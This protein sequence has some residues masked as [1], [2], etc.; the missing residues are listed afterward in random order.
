MKLTVTVALLGISAALIAADTIA[1]LG[2]YTAG[3]RRH[4]AFRPRQIVEAPKFTEAADRAWVQTPVDAF[5]LAQLKKEGL[6]P[7]PAADRLTLVRRLYHDLTGLPPSPAQVAAFLNDRSPD[8]YSRLV[9]TLL[10]SPRYGERWAQHWLDVVRFAESEGFE[11][12]TH[13]KDVWRYRDYVIR[14]F[15]NDKP[16]D[17]FIVEQIAGDEL[18]PKEDETLIAAGFNRLGPVRRNAGNQEVAS[19]RNEVLTEMTNVV[20]SA[21]LGVTV[22]CAR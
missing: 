20:C 11:Y 9:N 18:A 2:N 13:L 14:A 8:A 16:F 15:R 10:D 12:D 22:G 4:W 7:S 19:S 21:M 3:E 5:I 17:R 6:R 1:P